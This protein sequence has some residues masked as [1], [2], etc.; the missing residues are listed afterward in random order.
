M[1]YEEEILAARD[2]WMAAEVEFR[3]VIREA[4]QQG[5]SVRDIAALLEI[6]H[7]TLWRWMGSE[8][9][10]IRRR[11]VLGEYRSSHTRQKR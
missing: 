3:E 8:E 7:S 11:R 5:A 6:S 9:Q 1:T 2:R 4:N 10:P